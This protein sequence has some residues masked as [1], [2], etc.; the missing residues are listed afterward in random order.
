MSDYLWLNVKDS[1][2]LYESDKECCANNYDVI[3]DVSDI[4]SI[5]NKIIGEVT[6]LFKIHARYLSFEFEDINYILTDDYK[7]YE[8]IKILIPKMRINYVTDGNWQ[9]AKDKIESNDCDKQFYLLERMAYFVD[10]PP[11]HVIKKEGK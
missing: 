4:A 7:I 2:A 11:S 10:V 9:K 3:F 6:F 8:I 1:Q 5:D